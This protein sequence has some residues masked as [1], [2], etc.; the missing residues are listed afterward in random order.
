MELQG[1]DSANLSTRLISFPLTFLICLSLTCEMIYG[2]IIDRYWPIDNR[3]V[4]EGSCSAQ[5]SWKPAGCSHCRPSRQEAKKVQSQ[6]NDFEQYAKSKTA[7]S[8][9]FHRFHG[10]KVW[11]RSNF[12]FISYIFHL[13]VL[14]PPHLNLT[15]V[16]LVA[17]MVLALTRSYLQD[18]TDPNFGGYDGWSSPGLASHQSLQDIRHHSTLSWTK[19][20]RIRHICKG[21][22]W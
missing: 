22:H 10:R 13:P 15:T 11:N 16:D 17:C 9:R 20:E 12:S 21:E 3:E 1:A 2:T 14:T 18:I 8:F 7:A 19:D 4:F 5:L 6:R